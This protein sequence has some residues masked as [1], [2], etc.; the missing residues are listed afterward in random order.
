VPDTYLLLL[1]ILAVANAV[2]LVV[3]MRYMTRSR[4]RRIH[5]AER[6]AAENARNAEVA[7]MTRGL[8][9][10]IK[11]PLSTV[12]LNAQLLRE[13]ILDSSLADHDR[14]RMAKRVDALAREA[15]RLSDVLNDFLRY[16]GRLQLDP[17][18]TDLRDVVRELGD[19]FAPQAEQ[20]GVK[21]IADMPG[22]PV[23]AIVDPSLIK[24]VLLN[25]ML[26]AVQAMERS[27]PG[28]PRLLTVSVMPPESRSRRDR[29]AIALR[30]A[31]TGPGVPPSMRE[32]IFDPYVSNRPGGNGLG[33][34]TARRIVEAHGGSIQ[35][36]EG[37]G[38]VFEVRLPQD[39][40]Q[41]PTPASPSS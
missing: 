22:T 13:E 4:D 32:R 36:S 8:A 18:R 11:N 6:S 17:R 39:A 40:L 14:E 21:L 25:L 3:G 27:D 24:Q 29:A 23:E 9:H 7:A 33:L 15:N 1:L 5:A 35:V 12:G 30:V 19:F 26:N 2:I 16:A 10:E 28:K 38:A 31:D 34:A 20:A 41:A 37:P